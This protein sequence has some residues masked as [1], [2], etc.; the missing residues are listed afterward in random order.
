MKKAILVD[1]DVII[2]YLKTGKGLLPMAYEKYKMII[3]PVTYTELLAS[4]TFDDEKLE[5]EVTDFVKKYF[6][7]TELN[8]KIGVE[9]GKI[10][11]TRETNLATALVA[12]TAK[13]NGMP[14]LTNE[15]KAFEDMEGVE[16]L[17]MP[18]E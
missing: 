10:V 5:S 14:L 15:R 11:R 12:A 13:V 4:K 7:V 6:D 2:E 8:Q 18:T 16:V 3:S 9:A 1:I 17:E